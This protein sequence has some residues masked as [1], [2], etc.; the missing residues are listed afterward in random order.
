[1]KILG[2]AV[3]VLTSHAVEQ[4]LYAK[5]KVEHTIYDND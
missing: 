2:K 3:R 1:M 5:Q 4:H